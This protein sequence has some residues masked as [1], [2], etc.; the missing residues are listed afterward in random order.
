MAKLINRSEGS[1]A[2]APICPPAE[3]VGSDRTRARRG[4][5]DRQMSGCKWLGALAALFV[6]LGL[7]A[8]L[9]QAQVYSASVT[10]RVTDPSGAVIPGA[11]VMATNTANG[12][13]YPSTTNN[14]GLYTL[15]SLPPGTYKVSVGAQGFQTAVRGGI[16]LAVSQ[17]ATVDMQ[18]MVGATTQEVTVSGAAPLLQAQDATT[19]QTVGRRLINDLPLIDRNVF[20]LAMLTPGVSQPPTSV[21]GPSS[22]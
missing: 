8:P 9:A 21:F 19:G 16:V 11:K 22:M 3:R 12:F 17:H 7:C 13:A 20:D 1:W 6:L 18:L 5:P 4:Q 14:A 2:V 10:G 15:L